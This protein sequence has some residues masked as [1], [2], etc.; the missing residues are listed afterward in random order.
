MPH[1][2]VNTV[3]IIGENSIFEGNITID[4]SLRIDGSYYGDTIT[5]NHI[6]VGKCGSIKSTIH[7]NSVVIEG[8][9]S[10]NISSKI[11]TILLPTAKILGDII[12]P[13][14]IIQHGVLWNGH[15][16]ISSHSGENVIDLVN[17]SFSS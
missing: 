15:C 16:T 17:Q 11:R 1:R 13:E 4:G 3:N 8:T 14:L 7:A 2:I 6:V 12:T 9:I 10:G 5:I